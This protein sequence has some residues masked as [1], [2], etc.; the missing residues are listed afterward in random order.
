MDQSNVIV[1]L[2]VS[3]SGKSTLSRQL[4]HEVGST[5]MQ[6]DDLRIAFHAAD[7]SFNRLSPNPHPLYFDRIPV[8]SF[9]VDDA[10]DL[11]QRMIDVATAMLPAVQV[12]I[13]NHVLQSWPMVIEGDSIHPDLSREPGIKKWV[14]DGHVAFCCLAL[15]S[16]DALR[17]IMLKRNAR[18][19]T[20]TFDQVTSLARFQ[21]RYSEWLVERCRAIGIPIVDSLPRRTLIDRVRANLTD[22]LPIQAPCPLTG[23]CCEESTGA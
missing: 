8:S 4:A 20:L 16:E 22:T 15:A 11:C 2:G 6:S 17:D 10:D 9:L 13:E 7:V 14:D 19:A 12:V 23:N 18:E 21:W 1:I 5:R 3:G